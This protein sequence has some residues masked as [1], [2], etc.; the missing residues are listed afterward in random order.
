[1]NAMKGSALAWGAVV[2]AGVLWGGAALVA[3]RLIEGGLS[4]W[5]L[6]LARFALGLPLLWW[7][8]LRAE[9]G[10]STRWR[11]LSRR[12]R[13]LM[14]GTG[15]AMALNVSCWFQGIAHLGAALPTVISICCAPV[16][17][18]LVSVL[19][20]YEPVSRQL[21]GALALALVGV[22]CVV[23]PAD[24][25][26]LAPGHAAGLAWSFASAALYAAVVLC[27]ARMPASVSAVTASTWGMTTAAGCMA[28]IAGVQGVTWPAD[29]LAWLGVGYTG[30]VTTSVAYLAFA[31]GAR[32]LSPTAAVVG[33]LIEPLVAA[34]LAWLLWAEPMLPRQ[35]LGALLLGAAMGLLARRA[36][37]SIAT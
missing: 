4:P 16:L 1:M 20:G 23:A 17:V 13:A 21:L 11:D 24:G 3:Q 27:N 31:W 12:Q 35:W 19:R 7:W 33:T 26:Q 32:R 5:S 28:A 34:L 15:V 14:L 9:A 6:A 10:T 30:V 18:A 37:T 29:G 36:R 22:G 8:H 25:W 2:S